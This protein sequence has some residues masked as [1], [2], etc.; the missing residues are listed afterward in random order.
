MVIRFEGYVHAPLVVF[1]GHTLLLG[2]VGLDVDDVT[3]VVRD[4]VRRELDHSMV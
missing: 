4:Q 2:G 1:V 3:D